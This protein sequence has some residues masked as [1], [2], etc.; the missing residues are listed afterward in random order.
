M[1][2][3]SGLTV[4]CQHSLPTRAGHPDI[5]NGLGLPTLHYSG[6]LHEACETDSAATHLQRRSARGCRF[7]AG[8]AHI[9]DGFC[10]RVGQPQDGAWQTKG[11]GREEQVVPLHSQSFKHCIIVHRCAPQN[12]LPH[13]S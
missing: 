11:P 1:R 4:S 6:T 13:Q 9:Y 10:E 7:K 5:D 8:V 12:R 2:L 3:S